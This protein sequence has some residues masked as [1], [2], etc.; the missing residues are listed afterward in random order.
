MAKRLTNE[1]RQLR[2]IS[3]K[4]L[5][6]WIIDLGKIGGWRICHFHDS[7]RQVAPGVFVGDKEAKGFPDTVLIRP[8]EIIFWELKREGPPS[9]AKP[10]PEQE[11]WL[12]ELSACGLEARVVRPS[13][14]E[15]YVKERLL[16]P[17]E[18]GLTTVP[19]DPP[20]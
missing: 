8:P 11:R 1:E 2:S 9:A 20:L 7:R 6:S 3:E 5:Q 16:R 15:G 10:T 14:F 12:A 19:R 17:R 4:A 18:G 13:D